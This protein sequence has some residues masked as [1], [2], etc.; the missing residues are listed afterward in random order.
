M[1][2][3]AKLLYFEKSI[4]RGNILV[5]KPEINKIFII[6]FFINNI[7][8]YIGG[9]IFIII[10]SVYI[11][12]WIEELDKNLK[13]IFFLDLIIILGLT[14]FLKILFKIFNFERPVCFSK[15]IIRI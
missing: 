6:I 4:F 9:P 10:I 5:D 11:D 2:G 12:Q 14:I 13:S 7:R 8:N 15:T 1:S 3:F